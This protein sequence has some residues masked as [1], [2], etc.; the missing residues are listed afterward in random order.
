MTLQEPGQGV[1]IGEHRI[2]YS[3]HQN[4]IQVHSLRGHYK[5]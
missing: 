5:F 1:S 3:V 4:A 2:I